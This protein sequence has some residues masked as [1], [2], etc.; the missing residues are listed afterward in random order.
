MLP[1]ARQPNGSE[2]STLRVIDAASANCWR[3][4]IERTRAASVAWLPDSFRLLLHAV[5]A[6]GRV[7]GGRKRCITAAYSFI[8][9]ARVRIA[10][11]ANDPL[12]FPG[13]GETVGPATLAQRFPSNDGRWLLVLVSEGWTKTELYLKDLS[14]KKSRFMAYHHWQRLYLSRRSAGGTALYHQQ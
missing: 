13:K 1:L 3:K 6:S 2:L 11:G 14:Q 9:L 12:I 7:A 4:N 10:G 8:S 5:S